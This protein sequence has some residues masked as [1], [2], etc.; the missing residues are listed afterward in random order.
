[1]RTDIL[2]VSLG[3][4]FAVFFLSAYLLSIAKKKR[5]DP[6]TESALAALPAWDCGLCGADDCRSF[7]R[8]VS[9]S[10]TNARCRAG[11]AAVEKRLS[12]V[13]GREPYKRKSVKSVAVVACSGSA[14]KI[15]PLFR[16]EG[17]KDCA[18]AARLYGGPRSCGSGCLGYGNC[19]SICP[20][21]AISVTNGLAVVE[22]ELCDGCG[23]CVKSCPTGV[24]RMLP[25][26]DSWYV[27]CSSTAD[28]EVKAESC[29]ASCNACGV[30]ARQSAGSEFSVRSNL[31]VP[32]GG[33]TGNWSE[34]AA[35][36]PTGVIRS[37]VQEK[38]AAGSSGT[39]AGGL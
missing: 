23:A 35:D 16:Y 21:Q 14:D 8:A 28:P 3:G 13:L 37:V 31:A 24:I 5:S 22:P 29:S 36:C 17:F 38:K 12:V 32:S 27:A 11:G 25:R 7:A 2:L 30:C 34:I 39:K 9:A 20:N 6:L 33:A 18:A 10:A 19:V 1:M 4:F 15:Q 26:R